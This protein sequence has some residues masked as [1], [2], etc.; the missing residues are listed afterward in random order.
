MNFALEMMKGPEGPLC[1]FP[2]E[3]N[4]FGEDDLGAVMMLGNSLS[5]VASFLYR[6]DKGKL[7]ERMTLDC[8]FAPGIMDHVQDGSDSRGPQDDIETFIVLRSLML[9]PV[10]NDPF[11]KIPLDNAAKRGARAAFVWIPY[12]E[13]EVSNVVRYLMYTASLIIMKG[14]HS[15]H[16]K[17]SMDCLLER[18]EELHTNRTFDKY[19]GD[20]SSLMAIRDT[21]TRSD[22]GPIRRASYVLTFVKHFVRVDFHVDNDVPCAF[23]TLDGQGRTFELPDEYSKS[24][25]PMRSCS[26]E[27]TPWEL[28]TTVPIR[29]D[30]IPL[31]KSF[32]PRVR[33]AAL[34]SEF[35]KTALWEEVHELRGQVASL[36][37]PLPTGDQ[38]VSRQN[39]PHT[40][41][42][43]P[44]SGYEYDEDDQDNFKKLRSAGSPHK[45]IVIEP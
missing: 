26:D 32:V 5:D 1:G 44:D 3:T 14:C 43:R 2:F 8:T 38:P 28:M 39:K 9:F 25:C 18:I 36:K 42:E 21:F 27:K 33:V 23:F 6:S 20:V 17:K 4:R 37:R 10:D 11:V 45:P 30:L 24:S 12:E 19:P 35:T 13:E 7:I 16:V 31:L 22:D 40:K 29:E 34:T 41:R 15:V